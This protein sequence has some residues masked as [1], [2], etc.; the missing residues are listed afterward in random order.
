MLFVVHALKQLQDTKQRHK[1]FT[2][3]QSKH[4]GCWETFYKDRNIIY[5]ESFLLTSST[6]LSNPKILNPF[7]GRSRTRT[8]Q[9]RGLTLRQ[10]TFRGFIH[11]WLNRHHSRPFVYQLNKDPKFIRMVMGRQSLIL[12]AMKVLAII[13]VPT[14]IPAITTTPWT[15]HPSRR[16]WWDHTANSEDFVSALRLSWLRLKDGT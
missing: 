11:N 7:Q 15:H 16:S 13:S 12:F 8:G 10:H 9:I 2:K 14:R 5:D 4:T 6:A 3:H 1:K